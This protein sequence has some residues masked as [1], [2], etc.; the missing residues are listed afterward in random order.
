VNETQ[1]NGYDGYL[2]FEKLLAEVSAT[3]VNLS[4][5]DVDA[6]IE[7]VLGRFGSLLGVDRIELASFSRE[8]RLTRVVHS[9]AV[10][11]IERH[12]GA[13]IGEDYP[14]LA[15]RL[16]KKMETVSWETSD[17]VPSDVDR[18]NLKNLGI[19]AGLVIPFGIKGKFAYGLAFG[20][21]S[22]RSW[23]EGLVQRFRLLGEIILNA[24][25]RKKADLEIRSAFEEIKE[26]KERVESENVLLREEIGSL[27][28]HPEILGESPQLKEVLC[29]VDQVAQTNTAVLI[30]GETGTGKELIARALH[31]QSSRKEKPMVTVNCGA[32]PAN[33][34][35]SELFGHE[36]GA[37]TGA[38][39]R[40]AGRF[41]V[42]DGSTIFLD[43]IGDMPLEIQVKLLR[44]LQEG[45]FEPLGSSKTIKVDVRV[46]AATNIDMLKAVE[47][48]TFR[49]DLYYR[50]NVFPIKNPPLRERIEDIPLL[51]L[52]FVQEFSEAVGKRIDKI[53]KSSIEAMKRYSWPGNIR[54]LRNVIEHAVIVNSGKP[55]VVDIPEIANSGEGGV[56]TLE[57][58]E[59][60]Y[61][62]SI[63]K[64]VGGRIRGKGG[65][66]EILGLKPTTLYSKMKKLEI[67]YGKQLLRP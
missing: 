4:A 37:F 23:P 28:S 13:L 44:V 42:A 10:E 49:Q 32:L 34:V 56:L 18:E 47:E 51:T 55:L 5:S 19:E 17:G 59:R 30:L 36:K 35:E 39:S 48:G 6:N 9:W 53:S 41:Q 57:E 27:R 50:L 67:E 2:R 63:L 45:K 25:L 20:H 33:L 66:A 38:A 24:L 31:N 12:P 52:A 15:E 14:W 64:Q 16:L 8:L 7:D 61:I 65:A 26:L 58:Y 43:E 22:S 60:R 54:E 3:F 29:K 11:G 62:V 1:Q 40:R 21:H 46:I